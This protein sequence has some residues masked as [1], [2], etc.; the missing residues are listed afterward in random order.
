MAQTWVPSGDGAAEE[1]QRHRRY[2]LS[3]AYRLTSS[4]SDAE[5]VV[6][7]VWPKWAAAAA[8]GGIVEPRAWLTRVVSR[9]ALDHLRSARVRREQYVGP[10]LP[11]P[12][13]TELDGTGPPDPLDEIVREESVR[14]ALLVVLDT[15]TPEQRVAFVLHD[16]LDVPFNEI[17]EVLDC[18]ESTAR[19]H[20]SRGRRRVA[21]ADPAP[22]VPPQAAFGVLSR[23]A[24]ALA[25]GDVPAVAALLSD[26]VQVIGDGAG[27]VRANLRPIHGRDRASR[28]LVG[29]GGHRYAG[30]FTM[31]PVLVNG[32]AG[33]LVELEP[34]RPR[35]PRRAVYVLA[36]RDGLI[37]TVFG[38][39]A[40]GK[41]RSLDR[42]AGSS[43]QT[44]PELNP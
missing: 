11:E 1:F 8:G 15:L 39:A 12:L 16:I 38:V 37:E 19:Q 26:R 7:Q 30:R 36:V 43:E 21:D 24:A 17:G 10:W 42:L 4:W 34:L 44:S 3:V 29:L 20:A 41:L 14:L 28:V 40:P 2:L 18:T 13:V 35:D 31:R 27:E 22:R 9:A 23:L 25:E 33:M 6:A 32:D 5:D